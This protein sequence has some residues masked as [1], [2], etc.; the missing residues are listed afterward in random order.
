MDLGWSLPQTDRAVVYVSAHLRPWSFEQLVPIYGSRFSIALARAWGEATSQRPKLSVAKDWGAF[1]R[2]ML[3]AAGLAEQTKG[4]RCSAFVDHVREQ[5][6]EQ[7]DDLVMTEAVEAIASRVRDR[8]DRTVMLS[9]N[10]STRCNFIWSLNSALRGLAEVDFFPEI[11]PSKALPRPSAELPCIPC[12]AELTP[13][14]RAAILVPDGLSLDRHATAILDLNVQRLEALRR[15]LERELEE[16]YACF[17]MGLQIISDDSLP[18]GE[19]IELALTAA[20][21]RDSRTYG[22][23]IAQALRNEF[24]EDCDFLKLAVRWAAMACGGIVRAKTAQRG[25]QELLALAGGSRE[26]V[27]HLEATRVTANA[28]FGMLLV[29]TG[30]NVGALEDLPAYPFVGAAK[31]GRVTIETISARKARAGGRTVSAALAGPRI[32]HTAG[33]QVSDELSATKEME[34]QLPVKD[35]DHKISGKDAIRIYTEMSAPIRRRALSQGQKGELDGFW[36]I[37]F[38]HSANSGRITGKIA[39]AGAQWWPDFIRR[40]SSDPLLGG[41]PITRRMIRTTV[42][43][44]HSARAGYSHTVAQ[45]LAGHISGATTMAYIDTPW[46]RGQ[47]A[48]QI[49]NFQDLLEA[50]LLEGV[51]GAETLGIGKDELQR[52]VEVGLEAGLDF[53]CV[54]ERTPKVRR[55]AANPTCDPLNPCDDCPVRRFVPSAENFLT[56]YVSHKAL[57]L[58]ETA[59]SLSNPARWEKIWL[60]WRVITE[61]YVQKVRASPHKRQYDTIAVTAEQMISERTLSLPIVA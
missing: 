59:F 14:G 30:F 49:R 34:A 6:P 53:V 17:R 22:E 48:A 57:V 23:R 13:T 24:G 40:Q 15:C 46:F 28:V 11:S 35:R 54:R 45:N 19:Q 41:L 42:L 33:P 4:G 7:V 9:A 60:P 58:A 38:G 50:A 56:L 61:T 39:T 27:R 8:G 51:Q 18:S 32:P 5:F 21:W 43:Q 29:D 36:L 26:V 37:S 10:R 44:I 20:D 47:L 25:Q 16:E 12:L 3:T 2:F 31:R 52:R 55:P 1:T